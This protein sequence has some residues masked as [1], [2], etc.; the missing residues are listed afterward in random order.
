MSGFTFIGWNLLSPMGLRCANFISDEA[1]L[2]LVILGKGNK[3]DHSM[4]ICTLI[5][6]ALGEVKRF[7]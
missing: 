7:L 3:D 1:S 4:E 6:L 5:L 2:L